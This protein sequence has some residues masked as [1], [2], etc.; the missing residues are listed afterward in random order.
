[1]CV[2]GGYLEDPC[3]MSGRIG[4]AL[5]EIQTG[6]LQNT[7][8][9][10][11]R[12]AGLSLLSPK[13]ECNPLSLPDFRIINVKKIKLSLCLT[14]WTL[15]QE[16]VWGTGCIDPRILA[17]GTCWRWVVSF[18][19]RPHYPGEGDPYI[20]D[21]RLGE[22]KSQ[23]GPRGEVKILVLLTGTRTPTPRSSSP[24]PVAIPTALSRVCGL[25]IMEN[26][27]C[28]SVY[29]VSESRPSIFHAEINVLIP[30]SFL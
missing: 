12:S 20:L 21:R 25:K 2:G 19:P 10:R 29:R 15:R 3:K 23:S 4:C 8:Q 26:G 16:D 1:L 6:H 7:S 9:R 24:Y 27:T 28:D 5:G 13:F 30:L 18:T 22:P 17:L 11:N 14:N